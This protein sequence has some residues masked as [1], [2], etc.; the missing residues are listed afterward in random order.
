[1]DRAEIDELQAKAALVIV[2]AGVGC[3]LAGL[4]WAPL[5]VGGITVLASRPIIESVGH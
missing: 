1:M 2:F 5:L 3:W 4:G